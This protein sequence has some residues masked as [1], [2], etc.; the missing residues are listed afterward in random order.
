MTSA[1][2][3]NRAS[4]GAVAASRKSRKGISLGIIFLF[5]FRLEEVP[6]LFLQIRFA[7]HLLQN[8]IKVRRIDLEDFIE[9]HTFVLPKRHD[10]RRIKRLQPRSA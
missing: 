5:C 4:S 3:I 2:D 7:R 9:G 1:V 10:A 6:Y 8:P